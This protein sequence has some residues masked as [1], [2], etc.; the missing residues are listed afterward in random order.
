MT[1]RSRMREARQQALFGLLL[2]AVCWALNWG[3]EGLR[4]HIL[5]F[6]LWSGY[7]LTLDALVLSRTGSSLLSRDP[8]R[9]GLCFAV[10]VPLWWLFEAINLRT[11]N[12]IY[13]GAED[14]SPVAY[15]L[16]A[17]LAFSTVVP[18][19]IESA[20]LM[21]TF[22]WMRR[23]SAG[24]RLPSPARF[25]PWL[26][27]A[28]WIMLILILISPRVFYPFVWGAAYAIFEPLNAWRERPT[29]IASLHAGDWRPLVALSAG[30][31]LCGF[32]WEMWNFGSYP[33]WTYDTPGVDALYVF[34]MPL[35][36]YVGYLPFAWEVYAFLHFLMPSRQPLLIDTANSGGDLTSG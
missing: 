16:L 27:A 6:P 29:L 33:R 7:V 19:V 2:V 11:Q 4:T 9:F 8:L 15:A 28:G 17:S 34:E 5:F 20:E 32:F 21:W 25:A 26:F 23:F 31:L 35:L 22:G 13:H 10:S 1:A 36:G 12:W 3:L 30:A 24:P 18:A 14:F